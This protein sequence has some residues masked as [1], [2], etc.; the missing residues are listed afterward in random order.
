[1]VSAGRPGPRP[2]RPRPSRRSL[3]AAGLGLAAAVAAAFVLL[4]SSSNPTVDP[5]AQAATVSS[6]APG[7]RMHMS[8]SMTSS[9]FNGAI[10]GYGDA[11]VDPRDN[12]VSSSF[13]LDFSALPQAAQA[14]GGTTMSMDMIVDGQVAYLKLPQALLGAIPNLRHRG[15]R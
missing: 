13:A 3:V 5:I 1:M 12:T 9:V 10:T 14:L 4:G 15:S 2:S 6:H 11:V 8:L 7:Y